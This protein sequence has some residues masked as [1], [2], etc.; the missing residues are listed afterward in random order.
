MGCGDAWGVYFA[1]TEE[2]SRVQFPGGPP[3]FKS[4]EPDL[5]GY[6]SFKDNPFLRLFVRQISSGSLAQLGERLPC[7]QRVM[8]SSPM[9]IHQIQDGSGHVMVQRRQAVL[10]PSVL[11]DFPQALGP[12][13][14]TLWLKDC[15]EGLFWYAT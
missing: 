13:M 3:K 9:C 7:K 8:G 5:E 2:N 6:L 1:C 15:G 12:L 4:V 11:I 10:E 14:G